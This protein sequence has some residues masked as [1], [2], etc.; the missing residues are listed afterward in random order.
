[1]YWYDGRSLSENSLLYY[2]S[3]YYYFTIHETEPSSSVDFVF[4][5]KQLVE[6]GA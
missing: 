4:G 2:P 1:M 5:E 3:I 6:K